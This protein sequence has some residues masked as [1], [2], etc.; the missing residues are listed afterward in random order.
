MTSSSGTTSGSILERIR[1]QRPGAWERLVDLYGPLIFG[2]AK[3][4]NLSDDD[5]ADIVQEVFAVVA[6]AIGRFEHQDQRGTFRG[7]LWTITL[8]KI[9]DHYRRAPVE[10]LAPG[11]TDAW[12]TLESIPSPEFDEA[13]SC[14]TDETRSLALRCL[15]LI[16]A[17]FEPRTWSA[18]T[19]TVLSGEDPASVA[20][21]LGISANA[22]RQYKSRVLRRLRQE[23]GDV[24]SDSD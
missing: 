3:R 18:F 15:E 1:E 21:D 2:W 16:Q 20:E 9:R 19:R 14:T 7:W 11:G 5:A 22:V 13:S 10:H 4:Q 8:N 6:A 17:E 24:T 12:R 23:L